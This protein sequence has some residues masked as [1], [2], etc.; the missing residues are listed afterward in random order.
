MRSAALFLLLVV[1]GC[2][3][4]P[5]PARRPHVRLLSIDRTGAL[6]EARLL[7]DGAGSLRPTAVDWALAVGD[8]DLARGR[9]RSLDI[10]IQLP[11]PVTA[12]AL[13]RLRGAV[14][15]EGAGRSAIAPFDD[16]ARVP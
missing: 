15:L 11:H 10:Q 2:P 13:V 1:T 7:V 16:I 9:A 12:G 8:R 6:L 14:H 5:P 4:L 3:R